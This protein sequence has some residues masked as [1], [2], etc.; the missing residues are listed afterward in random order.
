MCT[1]QQ[2]AA[3]ESHTKRQTA[4]VN[5]ARTGRPCVITRDFIVKDNYIRQRHLRN[6][7]PTAATTARETLGTHNL[8]IVEHTVRLRLREAG[9][10]CRRPYFGIV[11]TDDRKRRT[12]QWGRNYRD[13][14]INHLSQVL[15]TDESRFCLS[16]AAGRTRVWRRPGERYS[17]AAVIQ[18]DGWGGQSVMIWGGIY[19]RFRTELIVVST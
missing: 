3:S 1:S 14:T 12:L 5:G 16:R 4:H 9:L 2:Y 17:D 19:A 10:R 18:S 11:L 7:Q 6:R 13:W 8:R 15:F